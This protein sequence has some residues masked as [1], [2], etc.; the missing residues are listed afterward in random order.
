MIWLKWTLI[1]VG[2]VLA[3]MCV[4]PWLDKLVR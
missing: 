1:T 4:L 2:C 3:A